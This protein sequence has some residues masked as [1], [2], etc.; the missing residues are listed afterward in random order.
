MPQNSVLINE[1][2]FAE[3]DELNFAST[4]GRAYGVMA[5]YN[6]TDKISIR[7]NILL[8]SQGQKYVGDLSQFQNID[9]GSY[10]MNTVGQKFIAGN[11]S[12]DYTAEVKL[13]YIKLPFLLK[14]NSDPDEAA[15]FSFEIGPQINILSSATHIIDD[16]TVSYSPFN[17]ETKDLYNSSTF[18]VAFGLGADFSLTDNLKLNANLRFDYGLTDA[19]NKAFEVSGRKAW[20]EDR[21]AT[22]PATGG[23]MLGLTYVLD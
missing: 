18:A 8:S 6:F 15:F 12:N 21:P 10:A 9:S 4:W 13:N 1:A 20:S 3:G 22:N 23:L 19:E 11:L 7:T 14:I 5:G 2:D 17:F 16:K